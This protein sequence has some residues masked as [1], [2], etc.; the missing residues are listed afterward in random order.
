MGLFYFWAAQNRLEK[1]ICFA[2]LFV[3][4]FFIKNILRK[5]ANHMTLLVMTT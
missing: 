1:K 3:M 5:Q 4:P 2:S